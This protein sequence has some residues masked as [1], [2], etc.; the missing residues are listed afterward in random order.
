MSN[1]AYVTQAKPKIGGAVSVAPVG[2]ALPTD[3]V[4]A[5]ADPFKSLGYITEDG[6]T[7]SQSADNTSIKAWGGDVVI[8]VM[9]SKEVTYQFALM[10]SMNPDV[11]KTVYG[12][13]NV[14]GDAAAGLSVTINSNVLPDK[15]FVVDM[16]MKDNSVKRIVIPRGS[17]TSIDDI[18]YKDD[19]AVSYGI[20]ITAI[21]DDSGNAAYEYIKAADKT[22]AAGK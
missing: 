12:E 13:E 18:S 7:N 1:A 22:K 9:A 19:E 6:L 4:T 15:A 8:S 17:I 20:T 2:T 21:P 3:A 11:L 5:L 14:K 10:E 16:I